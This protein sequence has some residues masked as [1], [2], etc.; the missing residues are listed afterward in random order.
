MENLFESASPFHSL[1]LWWCLDE[2]I[3]VLCCIS[4]SL[5]FRTEIVYLAIV[6][7]PFFTIYI[8]NNP[9]YREKKHEKRNGMWARTHFK[10]PNTSDTI[11][12]ALYMTRNL[13][14]RLQTFKIEQKK[15]RN[16]R[17]KTKEIFLF[18]KS[19]WV[20]YGFD[21]LDITFVLIVD[22]K[23]KN[24]SASQTRFL[25]MYLST[26][27]KKMIFLSFTKRVQRKYIFI[28]W[29][30]SFHSYFFFFLLSLFYLL[31]PKKIFPNECFAQ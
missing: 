15:K 6:S 23:G 3:S 24:K 12:N 18:L 21:A 22:L 14:S 25:C 31:K 28:N 9:I 7:A 17:K 30:F 19:I 26:F 1:S 27:G 20:R 13:I 29:Y 2:K 5:S 4:F 16:Y 8:R 11:K 10:A